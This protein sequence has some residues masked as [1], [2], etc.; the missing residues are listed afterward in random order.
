MKASKVSTAAVVVMFGLG[1]GAAMA[2]GVELQEFAIDSDGNIVIASAERHQVLRVEQGGRV[3]VLAGTGQAGHA[4]DGGYATDATLDEPSGVAIEADGSVLFGDA[5]TGKL[6]KI[7]SVTGVIS[8]VRGAAISPA[9]EPFVK[10]KDPNT[11]QTWYQGTMKP[12]RW[13]HNL[14]NSVRF[15]LDISRDGGQTWTTIARNIQGKDYAWRV[16]A[17]TTP[18][19]RFRVT[20]EPDKKSGKRNNPRPALESDISDADVELLGAR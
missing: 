6:R 16:T 11:A 17:P 15:T 7:D 2:G 8:G 1:A 13:I 10:I 9:S 19:A 4:G 12:I 3:S 20:Q 14:G 18:T 5:A